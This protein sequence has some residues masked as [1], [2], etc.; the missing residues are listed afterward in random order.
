M[1]AKLNLGW[2]NFRIIHIQFNMLE[3]YDDYEPNIGKYGKLLKN[4]A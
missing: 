4:L 2:F 3:F 1:I